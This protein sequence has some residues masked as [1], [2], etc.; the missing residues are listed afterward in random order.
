VNDRFLRA[1]RREPVDRPPLWIMRQAGRYLPEYR[2]L[3]EQADFLTLCRTPELAVEA[4]LQPLRRFALDAAIVFSDIMM[5][6]E[7]MGVSLTFDPGPRIADPIRIAAQVAALRVPDMAEAVPYVGEAVRLLRRELDGRTP[8][9]GFC[10][11]PW[12]LA[13][14]LIEG[15]GGEGFGI[16][17]AMMMREPATLARLLATLADAMAD[18]LAFQMRSGA[19]AVQ[20]FDSWAGLLSPGDYRTFVMPA[21]RQ[22]IARLPADRVPV[23]YFVPDGNHLIEAAAATG[24]DV[25][26]VCW[27]TPLNEARWRSGGRL[28]V[29]GNL[30][31]HALFGTP[32]SV[33]ARALEVIEQAGHDPGHIMNLGHGILPDT[34]IA[35]VEALVEAVASRVPAGAAPAESLSTQ[36]KGTE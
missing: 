25:L 2:A 4:S 27:R 11:A 16:A 24:A 9:I 1:C 20:I 12:T 36:G 34:P 19:Q 6:L 5:P 33:R 7:G 30:D 18:Y 13:A 3:R 10:G 14:Y 28:A 8:V 35:S 17:K 23:I 32:E 21:V 26:G 29:Q 31:P 15:R 22:L